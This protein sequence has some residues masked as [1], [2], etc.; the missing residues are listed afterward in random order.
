MRGFV[1]IATLALLVVFGAGVATASTASTPTTSLSITYWPNGKDET[2]KTTAT[3][4][5][6]PVGGSL[7]TLARRV[8]AC[9]RLAGMTAPFARPRAGLLCTQQYGGPDQAL[10]TGTFRGHGVYVGLGLEDGCQIARFK[11]LGFLVP[12]FSA[13]RIG[14]GG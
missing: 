4:R 10:I 8:A 6:S 14:P 11:K 9:Q 2:V 7:G 1:V 3:L 5:C 13:T 12:G